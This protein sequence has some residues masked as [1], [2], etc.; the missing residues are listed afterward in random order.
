[1]VFYPDSLE[2][3]SCSRASV[4]AECCSLWTWCRAA[5]GVEFLITSELSAE[6]NSRASLIIT[7]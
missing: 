5:V 4:S 3:C 2:Q 6:E 7:F 1:M